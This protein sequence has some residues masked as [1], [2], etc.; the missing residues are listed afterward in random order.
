MH[1]TALP[2]PRTEA[3][4]QL[5][6]RVPGYSTGRLSRCE[7]R[8][9]AACFSSASLAVRGARSWVRRVTGLPPA[10]ANVLELLVAELTTNACKHS[11]S[12][13]EGGLL[14]LQVAF[15]DT[16]ILRIG[17]LDQGSRQGT[18]PC[19]PTIRAPG[20]EDEGGRGLALVRSIS[21]RFGVLGT[22]GGPLT[23][24]ALVHR[25]DLRA[26]AAL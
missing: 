13:D 15:L 20:A 25:T 16:N 5:P 24:W 10:E 12:G 3:P 23:V 4:P 7:G 14:T 6:R 19:F 8:R 26:L 17:V 22:I 18:V 9:H 21:R 1:T 11:A 2:T